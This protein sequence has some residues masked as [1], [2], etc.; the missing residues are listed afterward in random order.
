MFKTWTYYFQTQAYLFSHR[1]AYNHFI[2]CPRFIGTFPCVSSSQVI[3][4]SHN[5]EEREFSVQ[6]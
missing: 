6:L 3:A 4:F 1:K 2:A 5:D